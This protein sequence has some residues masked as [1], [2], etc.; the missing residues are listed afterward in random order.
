MKQPRSIAVALFTSLC[1][2]L[3][4]L[5]RC[6]TAEEQQ[7]IQILQSSSS[8]KEKDA[9]CAKLKTIATAASVPALAALLPDEQLSHSARYVLE[10]M[11]GAEAGDALIGA[12]Q[13]TQGPVKQGI[14]QSLGVRRE[15][16]AVPALV[17]TL[18]DRDPSVACSAA[19]ALGKIGGADAL[20]ALEPKLNSPAADLRAAVADA[21]LSCANSLLKQGNNA[22]AT[23]A[24]KRIFGASVPDHVKTGAYRGLIL[25]SGEHGL[26]LLRS[27]LLGNPGPAQVAAVGLAH[28]ISVKRTT[29]LLSE[30][31][32]KLTPALQVALIEAL[33]QRGENSAAP[34]LIAQL[35]S[36]TA[37]VRLA[38]INALSLVGGVS[39]VE[40]LARSAAGSK[41]VEQAAGRLA[42]S[43]LPGTQVTGTL[44]QS[45]SS[46]EPAIQAEMA[47]ALGARGDTSAVPKLLALA[48]DGSAG[49][50][51]ASL[52]ALG[53]LATPADLDSIVQLV[54]NS[55]DAA[56]RKEACEALNTACQRL[57]TKQEALDLSP[58]LRA[59][60]NGPVEVQVALLPICGGF[61]DPQVRAVLKT[62]LTSQISELRMAAAQAVC[63]TVDPALLPELTQLAASAPEPA[64]R[65]S[66]IAGLVRLWSQDEPGKPPLAERLASA[67]SVIKS[68][69]NEDQLRRIMAGLAEMPSSE[70]LKLLEPSL[71]RSAV[72]NEAARAV[73]KIAGALP[74]TETSKTALA[75]ALQRPVEGPA[76]EALESALKQVQAR[77]AYITSWQVAGPY[78]QAG[79]DFSALFGIP[80]PPETSA[81]EV[82][83]RPLPPSAD[84][85]RPYAMDLLKALGGEQVVAYARTFLNN[86]S[87]S[88]C[89][90]LFEL[91]SDDGVKLWLNGKL[92]HENN[93][94]RA[95]QPGADKV[96]ASLQPGRNELLL[97]V[98]QNNQG[99]EFCL[100]ALK[101]D[102]TLL[103]NVRPALNQ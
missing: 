15:Q 74:D 42:L 25:A 98:T 70:A 68:N 27:A 49:A 62:K 31:L 10:P 95:L 9:A 94:A 87:S 84:A 72:R 52:Q 78:R 97:K 38:S 57:L 23:R 24:F 100:R 5:A 18:S 79:K 4:V 32:P 22:E 96:R 34:A 67:N 41:G 80:F 81:A 90:V 50:R 19:Y 39:S 59:I 28:S 56:G 103:E 65:N 69:P 101:P 36:T 8:A 11:R 37:E 30:I 60:D 47:R 73:A 7:L 46:T 2:L 61:V 33:G 82:Q 91:G 75:A 66:A 40:P 58:L 16:K 89:S 29:E 64:L 44:V 21:C 92:V 14:V 45:L 17:K 26:E 77:A 1:L 12:L 93:V 83:W 20:R 48:K 71:D 51:S 43:Q 53:T 99:W 85:S 88:P 54:G 55:K 76:R 3:P 13:K 102:G 63:D 35:R 86:Q 6:Q